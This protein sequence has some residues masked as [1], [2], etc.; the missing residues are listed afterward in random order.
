MGGDHAIVNASER[1]RREKEKGAEKREM[2]TEGQICHCVYLAGSVS[3][4]NV[5]KAHS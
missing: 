2:E 4:R 3:S 5:N 1:V